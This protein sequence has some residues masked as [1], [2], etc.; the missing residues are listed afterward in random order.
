MYSRITHSLWVDHKTLLP[1]RE[2]GTPSYFF[3]LTEYFEFTRHMYSFQKYIDQVLYLGKKL[4]FPV[5]VRGSVKA[6]EI[7]PNLCYNFFLCL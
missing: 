3:G 6:G 2:T 7:C 1:L 4:R 5:S